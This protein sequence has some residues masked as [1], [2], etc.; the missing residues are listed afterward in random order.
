VPRLRKR[1]LAPLAAGTVALALLLAIGPVGGAGA[2]PVPSRPVAAPPT[3]SLLSL[4]FAARAGFDAA[5]ARE[6]ADPLPATASQ[7][8]DV[9]FRGGNLSLGPGL[10]GGPT[11]VGRF[12]DADG[13]P[14]G[15]Y[16]AAERYFAAAGLRVT[17]AWPDRLLLSLSGA[18]AAIDRAFGTT[19]LA[20]A[21]R[22]H[23]AVFPSSAPS[24]PAGLERE[25]AGV[26]GLS[27]GFDSFSLALAAPTAGGPAT[28]PTTST[29]MPGMARSLYETSPLYNLTGGATY[30]TGE[31]IALVLWGPG[32]DPS[33]IRTFFADDYPS[34]FPAPQIDPYPVDG[35][36]SPGPGPLRGSPGLAPEELTLDI[37]WSGSIAPGATIDAVY[38]SS[39][40]Q[41]PSV[42]NLTD[43]IDRA[44]SLPGVSVISMS[45]GT[46]ESADA[47]LRAAWEPLFSEAANRHITVLAATGDT[48]GDGEKNC[49]GGPA[50]EYPSISPEVIAVG[51]TA[52]TID[53]TPLGAITGYTEAGWSG[54]GG[55]FSTGFSAPGW[56]RV[57]SAGTTINASGGRRGVPD[58]SAT[59]ADNFLYFNGSDDEADGTSFATPL[60]SGIVADLDAHIGHALGF[61]TDRLYHFA[62]N[63]TGG[64]ADNG[65]VDITSGQNCVATATNGWDAVTGWGTPRAVLLYEQLAGSFVNLTLRASPSTVA[66]GGA[67]AVTAVVA[68]ASSGRR[69]ADTAVDLRLVSASTIGP[70]TGTFD[71]DGDRTNATGVV[72]AKLRVPGCYLGSHAVASASV[73]TDKLYG[74]ATDRVA[75]NLLGFV[76]GLGALGEPP[77]SYLLFGAIDG[78]AIAVGAW[79][80]R[81]RRPPFPAGPA[82]TAIVPPPAG[83]AAAPPDV[84]AP[85]PE[86][87]PTAGA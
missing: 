50:P 9:V 63:E 60:W 65:L 52:V 48:G 27:S 73:A 58:V 74:K 45:F 12:A 76:P 19:L 49:A 8:V 51:G 69:I 1:A 29:V 85:P 55:G 13:L 21:Y 59:A 20:G 64:A 44:L 82:P 68:N 23:P 30:P 79:L 17:H 61:F 86:P 70:C 78:G 25:V 57:G 72:T 33:D 18:P 16:A 66:P 34:S 14:A 39:G 38:T 4:P 6:V 80:G 11:P 7:S 31:T 2:R 81:R 3:G 24:L 10:H 26:V 43:A 36:P 35:A 67:V 56:Q 84:P 46:N 62:A 5:Y 22:G 47:S 15:A 54:S 32:Y 75:V 40:A 53:R 83:A 42:S 41:G 28:L 37:E 87:P 71:A 77:Y